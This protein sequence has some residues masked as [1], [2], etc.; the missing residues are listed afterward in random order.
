MVL[1]FWITPICAQGS[2]L[3]GFRE[4]D[5]VLGIESYG[6]CWIIV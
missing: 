1:G 3:A 6:D 2:I 4:Q 5:G